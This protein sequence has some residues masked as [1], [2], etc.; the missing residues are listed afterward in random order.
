MVVFKRLLSVLLCCILLLFTSAYAEMESSDAGISEDKA[1]MDETAITDERIRILIYQGISEDGIPEDELSLIASIPEL[2]FDYVC[3]Y[4]EGHCAMCDLSTSVQCGERNQ[5]Y[6]EWLDTITL[7]RVRKC[8]HLVP[9]QMLAAEDLA[10]D[11]AKSDV[12]WVIASDVVEDTSSE[13]LGLISN[14]VARGGTLHLMNAVEGGAIATALSRFV[15]VRVS[16]TANTMFG[17]LDLLLQEAGY[18]HMS[19]ETT[20]GRIRNTEFHSQDCQPGQ[21]LL[22]DRCPSYQLIGNCFSTGH[23]SFSYADT[24]SPIAIVPIPVEVETESDEA[25][26]DTEMAADEVFRLVELTAE[27]ESDDAADDTV[28]DEVATEGDELDQR[29]DVILNENQLCWYF[30]PADVLMANLSVEEPEI[31][32]VPEDS[33]TVPIELAAQE[34]TA[35]EASLCDMDLL[36]AESQ[37]GLTAV[38]K[39]SEGRELPIVLSKADETGMYYAE[40]PLLG[41]GEYTLAAVVEWKETGHVYSALETPIVFLASE[42]VT[43]KPEIEPVY[44]MVSPLLWHNGDSEATIYMKDC[45]SGDYS[46]VECATQNN[47][48]VK[49]QAFGEDAYTV[50]ALKEGQTCLLFVARDGKTQIAV[51][52]NIVNGR[53]LILLEAIALAVLLFLIL[54]T[55]I[56]RSKNQARFRRHEFIGITIDD[57][58]PLWLPMKKYRAGGVSVWRLLK[59]GGCANDYSQDSQ[60]LKRLVI[61]PKHDMVM[62]KNQRQKEELIGNQK[63][64]VRTDSHCYSIVLEAKV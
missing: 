45:F 12:T 18:Y 13:L 40:L 10:I 61:Y 48:Y 32:F 29:L 14:L 21:T 57:E 46:P 55:S 25:E 27:T 58:Q 36:D 31:P 56:V 16:S 42:D 6:T 39:D 47:D 62:I 41:A 1:V 38:L 26:N 37:F 52:V 22:L 3:F 35:F 34:S 33:V 28:A 4:D 49:V 59:I 11:L 15:N 51:P 30:K 19:A 54:Y 24:S 50:A 8:S 64:T 23:L 60:L 2:A 53:H 43:V 7:S 5:T 9:W 17:T 44:L 20:K 63:F